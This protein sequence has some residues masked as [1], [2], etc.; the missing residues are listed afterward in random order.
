M[1]NSGDIFAQAREMG[2][3]TVRL[4]I[5]QPKA[6]GAREWVC[7]LDYLERFAAKVRSKAASVEVAARE[8][9]RMRG[10]PETETEWAK[11]FLNPAPNEDECAFC[12]AM[13]VCPKAAQVVESAVGVEL[14]ADAFTDVSVEIVAKAASEDDLAGKLSAAGFIE[15]WCLAV[16]AEA[17]RRL[18]TG[19]AVPGFGLELGRA[20]PRKWADPVAVEQVLK[21][22]YRLTNDE[23]YNFKLKSPTQ[24]EELAPKI[25]KKT[26]KPKPVKEGDPKPVLGPRQWKAL[27]EL[28]VRSDPK[29]SVK[30]IKA[31]KTP[32]QPVTAD[33]FSAVVEPRAD[34]D[35]G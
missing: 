24:L 28:I 32:Y 30:P 3:K 5:Y 13:A 9:G 34:E 14:T 33:A 26:G 29:P 4:M 2:V 7:D 20:G 22:Q 19:T 8:Y 18:L 17:E 11:I 6:G 23:A 1:T 27:Q 15:D 21:D 35:L 12:K 10:S 31:I 16:R 25:D